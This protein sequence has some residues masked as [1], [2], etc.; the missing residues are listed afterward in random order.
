M[1]ETLAFRMRPSYWLDEIDADVNAGKP[2]SSPLR[3]HQL[4]TAARL[5]STTMTARF[6]QRAQYSLAF[7]ELSR[8]LLKTPRSRS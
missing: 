6:P 1:S 7:P 8:I 5:L 4:S 2:P 3:P